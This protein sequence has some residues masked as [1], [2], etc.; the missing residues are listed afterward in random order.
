[1]SKHSV[2]S[3]YAR[4]FAEKLCFSVKSSLIFAALP[5]LSAGEIAQY[6][7]KTAAEPHLVREHRTEKESF[8]AH[9]AAKPRLPEF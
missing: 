3:G 4:R 9:R 8:S 5:P 2:S 7:V 6:P 1:V